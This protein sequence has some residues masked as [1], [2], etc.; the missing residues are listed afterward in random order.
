MASNTTRALPL[1]HTWAR[2]PVLPRGRWVQAAYV[3]IDVFLACVN[4]LA[5]YLVRFEPGWVSSAIWG[6]DIAPLQSASYIEHQYFAFLLLYVVLLVSVLASQDLYRTARTRSSLDESLAV[7]KAVLVATLLLTAFIYLSNVRSISRLVVGAS[8]V[9]NVLTLAAWRIWKRDLIRR[10]VAAE[11]GARNVLIVGAGPLGQELARYLSEQKDLGFVVKGFLDA[12]HSSDPRVLGRIED[13]SPVARAN[14]I[15]E[16]FITIPSER[17]VVRSVALEARRNRLNVKLVPELYD[18]LG[19]RAP[20]EY[21]GDFPVMELHHEP[22]PALGLLVKRVLDAVLSAAA[23]VALS[24]LFAAI[25][26]AIKIDSPG[27][28]FYRSRRVGKKGAH[29]TC[30]KF[31][32]MVSDADATKAELRARNERQGPTFKITN[33]PRITRLGRLLRKYSLDELPQLWNVFIGD[34]SLVGPRP[35]PLDDCEQYRLEHLRRL[36]VTPGLTGLW[37]VSARRDP[38]FERNLALDIEYIDSWNLWLDLKIVLR[39]IPALFQ[40]AGD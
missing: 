19:W 35:H 7:F 9:L 36:D 15:D 30:Y 13:L 1:V 25:A 38:S 21:L 26:I 37:Q 11:R 29:F 20:L 14:F 27:P 34:M 22:I 6:R 4:A 16:I 10:R 23:L 3:S 40:A 39:T 17:E 33:D 18:G 28:V 2:G 32:S 12:N 31:R 8:G 24:P 5:I